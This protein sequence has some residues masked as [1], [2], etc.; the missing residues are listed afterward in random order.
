MHPINYLE[1]EE[2]KIT[3]EERKAELHNEALIKHMR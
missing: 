1:L 3:L 2:C